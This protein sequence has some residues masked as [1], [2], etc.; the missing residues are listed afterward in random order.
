[1]IKLFR[2]IAT[3]VE[4]VNEVMIVYAFVKKVF[5]ERTFSVGEHAFKTY[6]QLEFPGVQPHC[7]AFS[8]FFTASL[9][10]YHL[11]I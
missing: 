4:F 7:L 8:L 2:C 5:T 6:T 3:D 1:M 10:S 9:I 11:H